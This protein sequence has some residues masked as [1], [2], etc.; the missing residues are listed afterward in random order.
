MAVNQVSIQIT[1]SVN[2]I[3]RTRAYVNLDTASTL[4]EVNAGLLPWLGLLNGV[5]GGVIKKAEIRIPIDISGLTPNTPATGLYV[6]SCGLLSF[7]NATD[8]HPWDFVVP[9][10]LASLVSGNN[11][12][13]TEGGAIDVM[14]DLM[15]APFNV[16]G[17]GDATFTDEDGSNLADNPKNAHVFRKFGKDVKAS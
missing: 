14:V 4:S 11:L 12:V 9:A 15:A 5:T 3:A 2:K 13:M 10:V 1:D 17:T 6:R 16:H 7:P 8:V